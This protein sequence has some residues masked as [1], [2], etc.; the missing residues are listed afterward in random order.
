VEDRGLRPDP[1]V[2]AYDRADSA[3]G[4]ARLDAI[5][6]RKELSPISGSTVVQWT[7]RPATID[8]A[9][10]PA[11]IIATVRR[12]KAYWVPPAWPE[13]IERLALHGIAF[14]RIA[15]PRTLEVEMYRIRDAKLDEFF[16]G[17]ARMKAT[18][19]AEKRTM[20]WAPGSVR[21]PADQPLGDLASMLLEPASPDSFF[22]WG[23]FLEVLQRVEYAEAYVI[24]PMAKAMLEEDPA[25]RAEFAKKLADDAAFRGDP[26][27]RLRW[28][29]D[30]SPYADTML[31][32]YP[33]GRE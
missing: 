20:T 25:L 32:L 6:S 19:V 28:F 12:P 10:W 23:F 31:M 21:V 13:V 8:V 16:E 24:E 29:Y 26:A 18:P 33:V 2:V 27:A 11:K 17:H 4:T 15:A 22:Q 5:E 14:E 30:R 1:L 3:Q 9:V 7:G